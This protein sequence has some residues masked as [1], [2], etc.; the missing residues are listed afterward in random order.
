MTVLD[1]DDLQYRSRVRGCLLG[2]AIGDALGAPVEFMGTRQILAQC[3]PGGVSEFLPVSVGGKRRYGLITDDTQMTLFTAEGLIRA[4]VRADYGIGF[5]VGVIHHAYDRWLDTQQL[6]G[7]DGERDG[8]LINQEWLY[9]PRAPGNTCLSALVAARKGERR[10]PQFGSRARNNSKG[11][12][13]VMR[14]APFGLIPPRFEDF[15]RWQYD[16][17]AQASDYTHGHPTAGASSGALAV[18]IGAIMR[19]EDLPEA[20]QTMI[21]LLK[22]Q[23]NHEETLRAVERAVA[24]AQRPPSIEEV[25]AL[26]GGWIAEEALAIA[27][28]AALAYSAPDAVREALSL[29]VTYGG[30]SDSTG[31]ICGNILGALH[32]EAGLP[33][34]LAFE[35]EG[36]GTILELADDFIYEFTSGNHLHDGYG[37]DTRWVERY[38]GW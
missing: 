6:S 31:A 14:R 11:C 38:P 13:T 7:P 3:G 2:G 10:I 33:V 21:D 35:V 36:R 30:D 34:E 18:L 12:G 24:A 28:Y 19:G 27:L 29:S 20:V 17:A 1:L 32:G 5:T 16:A 4:S 23:P 22:E 8:W 25:E 37:R 15:L 26:G 9:S